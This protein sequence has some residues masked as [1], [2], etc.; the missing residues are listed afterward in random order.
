MTVTG[1]RRGGA[2]QGGAQPARTG[3]RAGESGTREAILQAARA[4]F[5]ERGYDSATIRAIAAVAGVDPALVHHFY[6]TKER[7]FAA[8]MRLPFVPSE[9]ITAALADES[10]PAGVSVGEHLVRT[11]L[12]LWDSADVQTAFV[13]I[14]RSAL[15]S[16]QAATMLREFVTRA[17]LGPVASVA[18][19]TDPERTAFRAALVGSHMLGLALTR[20]IVQLGP[21]AA[22]MPDELAAAIGPTID[23]Y[24]TGDL[25]TSSR[26]R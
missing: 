22:A 24:L 26:N 14:L 20:Y 4:Q 23:A 2:H 5:A 25:G 7:L 12:A 6:G 19:D 11:A 1:P 3:R 16:E 18:D 9:F 13:G 17:F 10:R 8:A 15:T 21:V